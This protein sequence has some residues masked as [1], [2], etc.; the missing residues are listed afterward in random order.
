VVLKEYN[1]RLR[2]SNGT[3][4]L[5]FLIKG[6]ALSLSPLG[7]YQI[8]GFHALINLGMQLSQAFRGM[9]V[10]HESNQT[11]AFGKYYRNIQFVLVT[12]EE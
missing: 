11:D 3:W 2:K 12:F 4:K 9:N 1:S 8:M 10:F 7:S 5:G 6:S